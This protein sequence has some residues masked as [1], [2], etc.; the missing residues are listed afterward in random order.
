MAEHETSNIHIHLCSFEA[1]H[2][3][4]KLPVPLLTLTCC[5]GGSF[6]PVELAI[7]V[8]DGSPQ[9]LLLWVLL[10]RL[11]A[12]EERHPHP[13]LCRSMLASAAPLQNLVGLGAC[14]LHSGLSLGGSLRRQGLGLWEQCP[15]CCWSAH[16]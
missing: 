13:E 2:H 10:R 5:L 9:L 16:D 1:I 12:L 8:L 7:P 3:T 14:R 4:F 6:L 11:P 15:G